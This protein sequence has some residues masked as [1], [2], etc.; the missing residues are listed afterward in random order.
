MKRILLSLILLVCVL[1]AVWGEETIRGSLAGTRWSIPFSVASGYQNGDSKFTKKGTLIF[2]FDDDAYRGRIIF[3]YKVGGVSNAMYECLEFTWDCYG[4]HLTIHGNSLKSDWSTTVKPQLERIADNMGCSY[5]DVRNVLNSIVGDATFPLVARNTEW[6]ISRLSSTSLIMQSVSN[7]RTYEFKRIDRYPNNNIPPFAKGA[8]TT[9]ALKGSWK[10]IYNSRTYILKFTADGGMSVTQQWN[11]GGDRYSLQTFWTWRAGENVLY[12]YLSDRDPVVKIN[13]ETKSYYPYRL[14]DMV[15][16]GRNMSPFSKVLGVPVTVT[17]SKLTLSTNSV[18][19]LPAITFAKYSGEDTGGSG[20]KSVDK[21][22][23]EKKESDS[24][25]AVDSDHYTD[26]L[27]VTDGG[28][29]V[30]SSAEYDLSKVY[31]AVEMMPSYP[32]GEAALLKDVANAIKYPAMA[33]ENNIQGRVVVKFVV[34]TDGSVGSVVVLRGKD[35][36][37]DKEAIRVVKSLPSK[38]NPGYSNGQKVACWY[39]LPINFRLN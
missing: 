26:I 21:G 20:S 37:L 24:S 11:E 10:G 30:D 3:N 9:S 27:I 13:G 23:A 2:D 38:F 19:Y 16:D 15:R 8:T 33:A 28:G 7:S 22:K 6:V 29:K 12:Y 35:P 31:T 25:I 34:N 1:P 5:G 4:N 17:S 36:D 39:T 32:G 18:G 14:D